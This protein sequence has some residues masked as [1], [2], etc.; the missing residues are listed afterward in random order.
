MSVARKLLSFVAAAPVTLL[1]INMPLSMPLLQLLH[2]HSETILPSA[3]VSLEQ[4]PSSSSPKWQGP[5]LLSKYCTYYCSHHYVSRSSI[6]IDL[7][8][9]IRSYL[10]HP[11]VI[12]YSLTTSVILLILKRRIR[13]C[14]RRPH[15]KMSMQAMNRG[16]R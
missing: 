11:A 8:T 15:W 9:I 4:G 7:D 2:Q 1:K 13:V 10:V 6:S 14:S 3:V 12:L 5:R 16:L